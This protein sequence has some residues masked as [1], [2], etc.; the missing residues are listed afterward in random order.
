M[1]N[2]L[3][4]G[5]ARGIYLGTANSR[6]DGVVKARWSA[7]HRG[8]ADFANQ[9]RMNGTFIPMYG[10]NNMFGQIRLSGCSWAAAGA[11][12]VT[13]Q[14]VG[15]P[16]NHTSESTDFG[17]IPGVRKIWSSTPGKPSGEFPAPN[18]N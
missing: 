15:P 14:V 16:T 5:I 2:S 4:F 12:G 8:N 3:L 11:V 13:Y 7:D 6:S 18:N 17:H 1:Q 10:L 9:V